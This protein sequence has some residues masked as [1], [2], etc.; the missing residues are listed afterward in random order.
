MKKLIIFA[1]FLLCTS[2]YAQFQDSD[3]DLISIWQPPLEGNPVRNYLLS[4]TVQNIVD[5]IIIET[6]NLKDSSVALS[7]IGD[8]AILNIWAISILDDTSNVAISDTAYYDLGIGI[9]PP[10]GVAWE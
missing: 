7:N 1:L 6:V 9:D 2:S 4:Y 5:S 10:S 3:G 8:W